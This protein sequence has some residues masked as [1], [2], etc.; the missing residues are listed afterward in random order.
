MLVSKYISLSEATCRCGCGLVPQ[1]AML[2]KFD[3]IREA[4]G[5][6]IIITSSARC[7]KHNKKIGGSKNSNHCKGLALD[8]KRTGDLEDF[9]TKNLDFFNIWIEHVDASPTWI[10]VQVVRPQSGNR[11]FRP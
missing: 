5:A 10:H 4:F 1:K 7:E 9:I 3:E 11:V 2:D 6:P 8:L